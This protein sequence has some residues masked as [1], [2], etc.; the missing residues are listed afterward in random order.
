MATKLKFGF[1]QPEGNVN[2]I[3]A[4]ALDIT[5]AIAANVDDVKIFVSQI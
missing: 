2:Q 1:G 5:Y 4:I 3:R